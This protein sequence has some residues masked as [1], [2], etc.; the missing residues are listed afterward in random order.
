MIELVEK[1]LLSYV[2]I[3]KSLYLYSTKKWV[4]IAG[5]FKGQW[6]EKVK[7]LI[8]KYHGKMVPVPHN[9]T[10]YLQPLDLTV[11]R[12]C[13]SL[14]LDKPQIWYAEHEQAQ[15]SK[16]IAPESVSVDL[17][18]SILKP[19]HAKLV[20]QCYDHIRT[21]KDIVKNGWRR[22]GTTKAIKENIWKQGP[23][24]N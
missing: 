18:I 14:L 5:V 1:V 3:K 24:E 2:R 19:V 21:E 6:M 10:N 20:N 15:I 16:G 23:F 17:K 12:S 4:L 8:E 7:S 9:V 13:K 22:S 11:N